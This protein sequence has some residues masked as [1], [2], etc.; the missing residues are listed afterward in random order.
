M[1]S[2]SSGVPRIESRGGGGVEERSFLRISILDFELQKNLGN[3]FEAM[4]D[5]KNI[6]KEEDK[7]TEMEKSYT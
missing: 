4:A 2:F 7:I 5:N 3:N 6:S 1:L